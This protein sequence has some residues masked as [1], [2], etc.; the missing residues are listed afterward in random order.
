[1]TDIS[2][3]GTDARHA[4]ISMRARRYHRAMTDDRGEA[5]AWFNDASVS[6]TQKVAALSG[7]GRDLPASVAGILDQLDL[8]WEDLTSEQQAYLI[9]Y[10]AGELDGDYA[11]TV[12]A[13][14]ST[15]PANGPNGLVVVVV[16]DLKNNNR[17]KLPPMVDV[18]VE[19]KA[20]DSSGDQ[21]AH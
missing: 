1:M 7:P 21:Y 13:A 3:A 2:T 12:Q 18:Y 19:M 6:I 15:D 16:R 20:R 5:L 10:R 14:S 8:W 4:G 11:D 9:K 17:F